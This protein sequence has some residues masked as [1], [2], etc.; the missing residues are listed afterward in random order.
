MNLDRGKI[1]FSHFI[2]SI[3]LLVG[4]LNP[5][6]EEQEFLHEWVFM[7]SHYILFI[8]GL[9]ISYKLIRGS[10]YWII[11]SAILV[12]LWHVPYFFAL[13]GAFTIF[14]AL[15]DFTFIIAGILA[16]IGAYGLSLFSWISILILWMMADTILSVV[17]LLELPAYSNLAYSF[18]PYPPSEELNTAIAMWI[19]MSIIIVYVFGK[20]LRQL[21]F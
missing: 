1:K 5:F 12:S 13:A 21:L 6:T 20:F 9:L 8:G 11:P 15:N 10:I 19:M 3:I 14:R 7:T 4:A 16:G 18:S 17:F 2:P